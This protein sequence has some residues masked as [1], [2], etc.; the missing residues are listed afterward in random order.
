MVW[1]WVLGVLTLLIL[2]VCWTRAGVLVTLGDAMRVDVTLGWLHFQVI[3]GKEKRRREKKPPKAEK[4]VPAEEE[5]KSSV[6]KPSLADVQDAVGTLAAPLKR[7]LGRTRRGICIA[8]LQISLALGG[9]ED[10]AAAAKLY[11][12]LNA[13]IWAGMPVLERLLDISAPCIHTEV[14]F[15]AE[16]TR[17][18]GTVGVSIR[19]GTVLAVGFGIAVPALRWF[20]RYRRNH[21]KKRP[22]LGKP[23]TRAA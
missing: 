16:K 14:D 6:P 19:I 17:A 23:E 7:A 12:E 22:A 13:G 8:P 11:G 21:R 2:L 5:K 10:P 18:E 3:P 4:G 9:R 1:R 15:D 20:L